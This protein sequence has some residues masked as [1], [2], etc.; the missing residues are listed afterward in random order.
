MNNLSPLDMQLTIICYGTNTPQKCL[1]A[2]IKL[3]FLGNEPDIETAA[4]LMHS[5]ASLLIEEIN[6]VTYWNKDLKRLTRKTLWKRFI[7]FMTKKG[8]F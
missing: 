4:E 3:M 1:C 7:D 2:L 5:K 6:K 8:G